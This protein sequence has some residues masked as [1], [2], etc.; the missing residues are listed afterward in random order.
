MSSTNMERVAFWTCRV[1]LWAKLAGYI[2][3]IPALEQSWVL[4]A[5]A[6]A[7]ALKQRGKA[8]VAA[9]LCFPRFRLG[10]GRP[11][12][13]VI[14]LFEHLF[15]FAT[16]RK[17]DVKLPP[18]VTLY[19]LVYQAVYRNGL[20]QRHKAEL[21]FTQQV[22]DSR[23]LYIPLSRY[24]YTKAAT[25]FVFV[26]N[27]VDVEQV[28]TDKETFPTRGHTGFSDIL[29]EGLLGLTSGPTHASHRALV[30]S[31][32]S[33]KHL[34]G[35]ADKVVEQTEI[36]M[37]KWG[38]GLQQQS[39]A[40]TTA[41]KR[42]NA[43]YDLSMLTLDIIML[44]AFGA[45]KKH[46]SQHIPQ[47][48]NE[49]AH[50]LDVI[51]KDVIVRTALIGYQYLPTLHRFYVMRM[52]RETNEMQHQLVVD[53]MAKLEREPNAPPTMLSEMLR[54]RREGKVG[55]SD[56]EIADELFTIRGAGHETTSNTLCW[57]MLLLAQNPD[58]MQ[59]L[60]EEVDR[61]CVSDRACTFDEAKALSY[62]PHVVME[63]LRLYPT[64]PHFP[65]ECHKDC[66]LA[67]SGFDLPEGSM[68]LVS[69]N[70]MNR[71]R[72]L[73]GANA[74][75][76]CPERF[77]NAGE[78]KMG[79]PAG[80]PDGG[81]KFGFAPFGAANRSCVGQRLALL[82]A[83]QILATLVKRCEWKLAFPMEEIVPVADVT[84]GPKEGLFL[85]ITRRGVC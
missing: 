61:V 26:S 63:T 36:M 68:V 12:A 39:G 79:V 15:R 72:K 40:V 30:I 41:P 5:L 2:V 65:R 64:V 78:M 50:S 31:F 73:W 1:A 14:P 77:D 52:I 3:G 80:I 37:D 57:T 56:S 74:N 67:S 24:D 29:G 82:E 38:C 54:S 34:R 55:L 45:D 49:N 17:V 51:L 35:Y 53:C 60:R 44:S 20:W 19:Q 46:L 25:M 62:A 21:E 71:S 13:D 58:K 33:D 9:V 70:S 48:E 4:Q 7:F 42:I 27:P 28:L 10:V 32:L 43:Q 84:L 59:A 8:L 16:F 69:Q 11:D 83:V 76:F 22:G 81:H 75:E 47:E 66:K 6:W 85:D 18:S 23:K